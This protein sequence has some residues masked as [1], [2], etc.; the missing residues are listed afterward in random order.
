VRRLRIGQT[1]HHLNLHPTAGAE[2]KIFHLKNGNS[3]ATT[4][5][6]FQVFKLP[7]D[8]REKPEPGA[9]PYGVNAVSDAQNN[10]VVVTA[11]AQAMKVVEQIIYEADQPQT[12]VVSAKGLAAGDPKLNVVIHKGDTIIARGSSRSHP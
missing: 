12:I 2:F 3:D 9:F 7:E 11:P 8:A 5:L 6:L 4:R 10:N 1:A